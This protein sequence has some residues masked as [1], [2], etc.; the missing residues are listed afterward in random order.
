[1][2]HCRLKSCIDHTLSCIKRNIR[3]KGVVTVHYVQNL[4]IQAGICTSTS[5]GKQLLLKCDRSQSHKSAIYHQKCLPGKLRYVAKT[6]LTI[7]E[8]GF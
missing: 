4:N 7:L 5:H 2:C 6:N 3:K 8:K 1:M